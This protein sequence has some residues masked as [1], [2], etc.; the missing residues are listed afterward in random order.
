MSNITLSSNTTSISVN[1]S[2][3][4]ITVGSTPSVITVGA[5]Q[6]VS[7]TAIR[8]AI[9]NTFPI[10]YDVSTGI[11]SSGVSNVFPILYDVSTGVISIDEDAIV[12]ETVVDNGNKSGNI[13]LDLNAG[14]LH[15][16]TLNGDVT[17]ITFANVVSGRSAT[18]ILTQDSLGGNEL[19]TTTFTSNWT[20]WNFANQFTSLDNNPNAWNVLSVFYDGTNYYASLV[21]EQALQIQNSELANSNIIVNGTT[22]NLGSS[23]QISNLTG[24]DTGD[25]AEGTNLYYTQSRFDTAFSG[26]STSNLS[27]GT[28][29]YY[30]DARVDSHLSG[31]YGITYTSGVIET[32]NVEIQAQANSAITTYFGDA[33]NFPFTFNGNIQVQGNIDYVNV[34]DLLVN[35]QSITLNY[36]NVL[37]D[38]FVY[39]DRTGLNNAHIKWNETSDQWEIYDGT[40]TYVI[41]RST[42][43]LA[44]GTNLYWTTDRGNTNSDAWL[45]TKTTTDL[46][47]G[48]NLYFSNTNLA[49]SS[50]THL[51]EGT[52]LYFTTDRANSAIEAHTGNIANLTGDV[53]TTGNITGGYILAGNDAGGDGIFIGDINGA[54]QQEVRNTTG[55][56]IVKGKAV[57]LTGVVTGDTP[58]VA[59]AN[60]ENASQMPAIGVV[61]NN[62]PNT[63]TG[64]IVTGG[65]LNIG[66]HGFTIGS[67]LF[68]NG[69]GDLTE[70]IPL[71]ESNLLQKIGKVV[72]N[73]QIIVQGA[74]RTNA[75]P[76]LNEGNIFLGDTNN[77]Q[78][79]VAPHTN[80]VTTGNVFE[81]ANSLTNINSI[82]TEVSD[83]QTL[84]FNANAGVLFYNNQAPDNVMSESA[85][86]TGDGY[87][88]FHNNQYNSFA[89]TLSYSGSDELEAIAFAG[90]ITEG[91]ANITVTDAID[92]FAFSGSGAG[93]FPGNTAKLA[94]VSA[95]MSFTNGNDTFGI[96]KF[97]PRSSY[98][99]SVD[100]GNNIITMNTAATANATLTTSAP[101]VVHEA[102]INTNTGAV[103]R[104]ASAYDGFGG[105][106]TSILA[107]VPYANPD[108]YGYASQ[109][110]IRAEDFTNASSGSISDYSVTAGRFNGMMHARQQFTSEQ[111][112]A[113]FDSLVIGKTT[114]MTNRA[115]FDVLQSYGINMM[116]D[117]REAQGNP[118]KIPQFLMKSYTDNSLAA[119]SAPSAGPRLFFTS[120]YGNADDSEF[121]TYPR[122]NQE[123]GRLTWWGTSG[124]NTGYSTTNPPAYISVQAR[125][126][127]SAGGTR[128]GGNV[129]MYF[130]AASDHDSRADIFL[131]Y[132][133]G[134]RLILGSNAYNGGANSDVIIGHAQ[135]GT[136]GNPHTAYG[137]NPEA[138]M[139]VNYGNPANSSGSMATITNGGRTGQGQVGEML[140]AFDRINNT[141]NNDI[142]VEAW[143]NGQ[144]IIDIDS[145][146]GLTMNHYHL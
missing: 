72:N 25:L 61:K 141:S 3:N 122:Q 116:W 38:A 106:K 85:N 101:G 39:I 87:G 13:T 7:N 131:T 137:T 36:G 51:P 69:D 82:T 37:Q 78:R 134:G 20:A 52:N 81:L 108:A 95:Y 110:G 124:T 4:A 138:W 91:S 127:W 90:T 143:G 135:T 70:T 64:E 30:T 84:S 93:A 5:A 60:A 73:Q 146:P 83:T 40:S 34:E 11:I 66:T 2:T 120:A 56:T 140:L 50:T 98:V 104:I 24:L 22:I 79:T 74:G 26:K 123:L 121:A 43:D 80:F 133:Q 62:I 129:D 23:G 105:S 126:D 10:Q 35:D 111:D 16:V 114:N 142:S 55:N 94:N 96:A 8:A 75:T 6:T 58:H 9:G 54:I 59:L 63:E 103:W 46:A 102:L 47:E 48:T 113:R 19:D 1:S 12:D 97:F 145:I 77:Q 86:I 32:T 136:S 21:V 144:T 89:G 119:T 125:D 44:E 49:T 31:G 99:Q 14:R 118:S 132:D 68:I 18:V 117:G 45:T 107:D 17:G 115:E 139:K 100:T 57:Y 76:N 112:F 29:L 109:S 128:H 88:F 28:N 65:Q 67:Q 27:E 42:S 130:A 33:N 71:S 41:P 92:A 53:T 15:K